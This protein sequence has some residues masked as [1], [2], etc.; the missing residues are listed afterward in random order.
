MTT[1]SSKA[2]VEEAVQELV[3]AAKSYSEDAGPAGHAV[4]AEILAQTRKLTKTLLTPEM[5]PFY[6]GLNMSEIVNIYAFMKLQ[7]LQAIPEQASISL[8]KLSQKTG[9]QESLLERM[10]RSLVMSGFIEQ[11]RRGGG[12]Y[13]HSKFSRAYCLE[14]LSQGHL[15]L[16]IYNFVLEPFIN[17]DAYLR[18]R[19]QLQHAREPEDSH[20]SPYSF[21]QGQF[22]TDPWIIM[23]QDP[24]RVRSFQMSMAVNKKAVPAVGAYD[25]DCLRNT[26]EE[27]A[28]GRV[29][30]VDVG[31]GQGNVLGEII[32][33]HSD[34][35]RPETCVL[36][37]RPDVIEISKT[38]KA[39][40][41]TAQRVPHDFFKE[42]PVKGAKAY[43]LRQIIHDWSDTTSVKILSHLA[44]AMAPDSRVLI[45]ETVL[46]PQ[47]GEANIPAV[48][49][50][51][52]VMAIGGK[53]RTEQAFSAILNEAGLELVRVWRALGNPT[54]GAC[55]ESKLRG[56]SA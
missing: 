26:A 33:A 42:Q 40:P 52:A 36:E 4:R 35:L 7:V 51:H 43:F 55:V 6:H 25:F 38:N 23:S 41:D 32:S 3:E 45:F 31:G 39:L 54:A 19:D 9:V 44:A 27:A 56:Q 53:E 14:S 13:R 29:Q 17:F 1:I 21:C 34:A 8:G 20:N 15:F 50:D 22:G 16:V 49:I 18:K 11:T 28:A 37:D 5:M 46:P 47:L 2:E 12:E 48:V 24:E 10:A 30:L